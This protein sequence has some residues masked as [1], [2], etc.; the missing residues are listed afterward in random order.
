MWQELNL[1]TGPS[2][3]DRKTMTR[4]ATSWTVPS[5]A[6]SKNTTLAA[7]PEPVGPRRDFVSGRCKWIYGEPGTP[8]WR[9]C[10]RARKRGD[11]RYC[12]FHAEKSANAPNDVRYVRS[13]LV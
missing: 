8:D 1:H 2:R 7:A 4:T 10:G 3:Y 9:C 6:R 11:S 13:S 5:P 12:E